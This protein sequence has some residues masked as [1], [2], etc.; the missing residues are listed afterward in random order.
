MSMQDNLG[1]NGIFVSD[2]ARDQLNITI[3]SEI[4]QAL[5]DEMQEGTEETYKCFITGQYYPK[6]QGVFISRLQMADAIDENLNKADNLWKQYKSGTYTDN[7]GNKKQVSDLTKSEKKK[8]EKK[9]KLSFTKRLAISQY[10]KMLRGKIK[11]MPGGS[12]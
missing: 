9:I 1:L 6:S 4:F 8:Y 7:D 5:K 11:N 2:S 10:S 3:S 12:L